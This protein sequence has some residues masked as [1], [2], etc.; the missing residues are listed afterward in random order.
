MPHADFLGEPS[1]SDDAP[2]HDAARQPAEGGTNRAAAALVFLTDGDDE[3]GGH[4]V[5]PSLY[6]AMETKKH[7]DRVLEVAFALVLTLY[8][9]MAATA[10]AGG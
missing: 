5:F 7:F 1:S 4:A 2:A 8:V 9:V 3:A 10:T 6:A